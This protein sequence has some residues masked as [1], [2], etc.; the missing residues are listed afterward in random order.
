MRGGGEGGAESVRLIRRTM[1]PEASGEMR[2]RG[3]GTVSVSPDGRMRDRSGVVGPWLIV[4]LLSLLGMAALVID[5]GRL[6]VAAQQVQNVVDGAALAG[7]SQLPDF[8]ACEGRLESIVLSNNEEAPAWPV[9]VD[10]NDD[11]TYYGPGQSVP[12]HGMLED[13]EYAVEVTGHVGVSYTFARIFGLNEAT[14]TRAATALVETGGGSGTGGIF[15]AEESTPGQTGV[16]L[17]G[18]WQYVDGDVHSNCRVIVNGSHQTVTGTIEYIGDCIINGSHQDIGDEV[19]GEIE[20]YPISYDWDDYYYGGP[21][22]YVESSVTYN[23]SG[24]TIPSGYWSVAGNM[25]VNGS[26]FS[27]ADAVFM[28]GGN[29]TINGSGFSAENCLFVVDG[30]VRVN[31]ANIDLLECTFL[32]GHEAVFNSALKE[33]TYR[34]DGLFCMALGTG[35]VTY[36]GANQRTE[37]IIFAPNG[38]ITYNGANQEVYNGGLCAKTITVNGSH[39]TFS[40]LD[41]YGWGG[42]G[43]PRVTLI[44]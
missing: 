8:D 34:D 38:R 39:G 19:E 21:Y 14:V 15:F 26:N 5:V 12:E 25:R 41:D 29:L 42:A 7:A 6:I 36:N 28:I 18:S 31:G 35:G 23:G 10:L 43:S 3:L 2:I 37:G 4:A 20:P 27:V 30:S 13:G 32:A 24:G 22:D 9:T 17:N 1:K 11:L 33:C 44:R 16:I 40:P